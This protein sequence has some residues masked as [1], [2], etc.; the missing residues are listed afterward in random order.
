MSIDDH[1]DSHGG[2]DAGHGL[3]GKAGVM[4]VFKDAPAPYVSVPTYIAGAGAGAYYLAQTAAAYATSTG[5]GYSIPLA[6]G[7]LGGVAGAGLGVAAGV[8]A[9]SPFFA[10]SEKGR[11][12]LKN[13]FSYFNFKKDKK[14]A[15]HDE[16]GSHDAHATPSHGH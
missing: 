12:Y 15:G 8:L 9:L 10:F 4:G 11:N 1:A 3:E 16:H 13:V 5:L 2:H 7:V 6:A 14:E